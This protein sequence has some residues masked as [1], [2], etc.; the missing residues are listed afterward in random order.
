MS[1][2][3]RLAARGIGLASV[4]CS[5]AALVGAGAGCSDDPKPR[6]APVAADAAPQPN[7]PAVSENSATPETCRESCEKDHGSGITRDRAVDACFQAH[8][9][10][11]CIAQTPTDAGAPDAGSCTQ[12]VVTV[13]DDCDSCTR[14]FCCTE[15]DACFG[16]AECSSLNACYQTCAE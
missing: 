14:A 7:R 10:T 9:A 4:V 12:P 5:V 3:Y 13:S 2:R 11:E 6:A 15:W 16:D 1:S 8:C